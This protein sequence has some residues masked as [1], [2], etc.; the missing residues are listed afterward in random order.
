LAEK[1]GVDGLVRLAKIQKDVFFEENH[2]LGE[3]RS[4]KEREWGSDSCRG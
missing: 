3:L 2:E 1:E 4:R